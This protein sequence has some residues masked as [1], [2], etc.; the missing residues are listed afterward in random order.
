MQTHRDFDH[1]QKKLANEFMDSLKM[2]AELCQLEGR[3]LITG[4]RDT[5]QPLAEWERNSFHVKQL[6]DDEHGI[7]RISVGGGDDTPVEC[8]YIAHRGNRK[9]CADLLRAALYALEKGPRHVP[10]DG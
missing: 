8:N 7:L 9:K 6:P 2:K 3:A 4:G 5:E 1:E 10:I